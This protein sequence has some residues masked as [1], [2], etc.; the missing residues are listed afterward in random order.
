MA[1]V[2]LDFMNWQWEV[3]APRS[4]QKLFEELGAFLPMGAVLYFEGGSPRGELASFF[5]QE[6]VP[7]QTHIAMGTSWP[8][9]K[10][11]HVPATEANLATLAELSQRCAEPELADHFHVYCGNEVLIAWFDILSIPMHVSNR[12]PEDEVTSFCDR[13]GVTYRKFKPGV[14]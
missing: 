11:F 8:R 6:S 14:E 3:S 7:E 1:G 10:T 4:T 2:H 5:E 9:P 13:L 12:F